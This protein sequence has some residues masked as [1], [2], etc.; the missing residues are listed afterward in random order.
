[1][2]WQAW[3]MLKSTVGKIKMSKILYS[4]VLDSRHKMKLEIPILGVFFLKM[5]FL[6]II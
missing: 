6:F 5:F 4:R 1:M 2:P 3:L